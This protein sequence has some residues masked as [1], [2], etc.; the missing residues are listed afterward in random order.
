MKKLVDETTDDLTRSLLIAGIEHRPPTGNKAQLLVAL[1]AGGAVGLFSAKAFGWIGTS[2]GKVTLVGVAL[3]VA[4][5]MYGV[6]P[7][8]T[9]EGEAGK[10]PALVALEEPSERAE[11]NAVIAPLAPAPAAVPALEARQGGTSAVAAFPLVGSV[12]QEPVVQEPVAQEPVA[13]EPVVQGH[14]GAAVATSVK[15]K[16]AKRKAR[17]AARTDQ[18]SGPLS[19]VETPPAVGA[20]AEVSE[21]READESERSSLNS[22]VRLVDDMHWA[23][24][25]NDHEALGRFVETYRLQFPDGQLKAEVAKFAARLERSSAR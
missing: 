3:G 21:P 9:A 1:G 11:P 19:A 20:S 12:V 2:A 5:A 24:R 22:E 13:Q 25:R 6:A 4:G 7:L 15:S 18:S 17:G 8:L 10:Q 16:G 14:G 23:A